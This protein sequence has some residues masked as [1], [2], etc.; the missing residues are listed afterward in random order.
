V[1]DVGQD[2]ESGQL[3]IAMEHLAGHTLSEILRP[4]VVLPWREA[5]QITGRIAEALHYAHS[6]GFVHRD[7]KPANV[8]VSSSGE[9]KIMD[10]GIAQTLTAQG[11][12]TVAGQS[13]GT[14]LYASPEQVLGSPWT[15]GA[16]S[17]RWVRS[18]T[19]C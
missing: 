10:F 2:V 4:G 8:M 12:L 17:S 6:C 14:P 13:V 16:I 3:Y 7:V 9:P 19:R 1:H 15:A 11:K 18:R 5:L